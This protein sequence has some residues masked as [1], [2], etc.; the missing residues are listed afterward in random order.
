MDAWVSSFPNIRFGFTATLLFR[1]AAKIGLEA[2]VRDMDMGQIMLET[3]AP[4]LLPPRFRDDP[5]N[6]PWMIHEVCR[7]VAEL[8][9]IS[10]SQVW[11]STSSSAKIL[12]SGL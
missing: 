11:R 2:V 4:Y 9:G 12:Y 10:V 5:Y 1:N 7:R 6:H 3:D 8:K